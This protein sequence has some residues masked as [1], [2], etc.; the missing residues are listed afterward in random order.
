LPETFCVDHWRC[1]FMSV[2]DGAPISHQQIIELL[3]RVND[4]GLEFIKIENL[5]TFDGEPGFSLGQGQ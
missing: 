3:G 5:C 2:T 1:R 4:A